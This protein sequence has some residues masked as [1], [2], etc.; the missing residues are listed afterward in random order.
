M[1][2]MLIRSLMPARLVQPPAGL[3]CVCQHCRQRERAR[4]AAR[5]SITDGQDVTGSRFAGTSNTDFGMRVR[6]ARLKSP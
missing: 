5:T 6:L 4:G 2:T 3:Q 1:N